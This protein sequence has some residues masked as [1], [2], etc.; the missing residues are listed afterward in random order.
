M[1]IISCVHSLGAS[2]SLYEHISIAMLISKHNMLRLE[3]V[4]Y[5]MGWFKTSCI[6]H[7]MVFIRSFIHS[8]I[9][10][11]IQALSIA[12]SSPLLLMRR[13]PTQHAEA[14]LRVKDLRTV[15]T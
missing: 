3:Y 7:T 11:F 9:H 10:S 4:V 1:F 15:P 14:P 2:I 6:R 5:S 13:H 8:F 12:P